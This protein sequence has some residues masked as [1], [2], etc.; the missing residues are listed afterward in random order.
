MPFWLLKM[1]CTKN[2]N[3][4]MNFFLFCMFKQ[5][6]KKQ[7]NISWVS[8]RTN[9]KNS[10][11]HL[12]K[13]EHW[14]KEYKREQKQSRRRWQIKEHMLTNSSFFNKLSNFIVKQ[15]GEKISKNKLNLEFIIIFWIGF[16]VVAQKMFCL[17]SFW[18]ISSLYLIVVDFK[19][20]KKSRK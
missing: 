2:A 4:T 6:I 5:N 13:K 10:I 17:A 15:H 14:M 3:C 18:K 7:Q 20:N 19:R 16:F 12:N 11:K 1:N 8:S 9:I